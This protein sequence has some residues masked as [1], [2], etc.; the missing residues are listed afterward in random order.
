[1]L[2]GTSVLSSPPDGEKSEALCHIHLSPI[3]CVRVHKMDKQAAGLENTVM[4]TRTHSAGDQFSSE[5][6][7]RLLA[8]AQ[9]LPTSPAKSTRHKTEINKFRFFFFFF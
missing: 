2:L 8:T 6:P 4:N 5:P 3:V 1:M 7:R 9:I